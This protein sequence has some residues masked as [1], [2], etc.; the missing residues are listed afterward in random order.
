MEKIGPPNSIGLHL[1][2]CLLKLVYEKVITFLPERKL[3]VSDQVIFI[4]R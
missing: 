1:H 3:T 4:A 2:V